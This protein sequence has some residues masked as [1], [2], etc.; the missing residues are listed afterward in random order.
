MYLDDALAPRK[1]ADPVKKIQAVKKQISVVQR[2]L[3]MKAM[4][5]MGGKKLSETNMM[6]NIQ[7]AI[8][9]LKNKLLELEKLEK[10][11]GLTID[12]VME[13]IES[14]SGM[15]KDMKQNFLLK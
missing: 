7:K 12:K 4:E 6:A 2:S 8:K 13:T 11:E 10:K 3:S 5:L 1:N 15:L 14:A 9:D